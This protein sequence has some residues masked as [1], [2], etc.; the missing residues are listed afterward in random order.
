MHS[1]PVR[2]AL[3]RLSDLSAH[4]ARR[5]C[6]SIHFMPHAYQ[7]SFLLLVQRSGVVLQ[8]ARSRSYENISILCVRL[9]H[10]T[11]RSMVSNPEDNRHAKAFVG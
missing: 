11:R 7:R 5:D 9:G 4:D 10:L 1:A 3:N 8:A 2:L 6:P